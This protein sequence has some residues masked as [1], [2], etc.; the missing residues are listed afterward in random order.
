MPHGGKRPGAGR[1]KGSRNRPNPAQLGKLVQ[2]VAEHL[3][4]VMLEETRSDIDRLQ[5]A[6]GIVIRVSS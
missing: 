1:K 2:P 4:A 5:A 3:G 6:I